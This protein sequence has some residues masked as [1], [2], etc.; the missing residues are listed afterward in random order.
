MVLKINKLVVTLDQRFKKTIELF[1]IF[2]QGSQKKL[3]KQIKELA[4]N[5]FRVFTYVRSDL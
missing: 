3:K 4:L 5:Y 2:S 1:L